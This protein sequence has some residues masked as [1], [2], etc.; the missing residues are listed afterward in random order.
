MTKKLLLMFA[1]MLFA[2]SC[3]SPSNPNNNGSGNNGGST[4]TGG[5]T[6]EIGTSDPL[7]ISAFLKDKTGVYGNIDDVIRNEN[8]LKIKNSSIYLIDSQVW[9][10]F[11]GTVTLYESDSKIV[12]KN[13]NYIYTYTLGSKITG[14]TVIILKKEAYQNDPSKTKIGTIEAFSK[15]AGNYL[16]EGDTYIQIDNSGNIYF[17]EQAPFTATSDNNTLHR[18]QT[19]CI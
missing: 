17:L 10:P 6:G 18:C 15:F 9:K 14:N 13:D 5:S 1:V 8:E 3:N 2:F 4:G 16:I 19:Y 7:K 11:T 12:M